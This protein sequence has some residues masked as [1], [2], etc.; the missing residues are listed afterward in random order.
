LAVNVAVTVSL[1]SGTA[2]VHSPVPEQSALTQPAK[3]DPADGVAT[4]DTLLFT[5]NEYEQVD[6]QSIPDGV[7][8]TVPVPVPVFDTVSMLL[9]GVKSAVTV[10]ALLIS[11]LQT[12]ALVGPI[13]EHPDQRTRPKPEPCVAVS[14]TSDHGA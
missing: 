9:S 3:E 8:V 2:M 10:L 13:D 7:L 14:V 1:D 5:G 6:P 4:S 12:R 11:T